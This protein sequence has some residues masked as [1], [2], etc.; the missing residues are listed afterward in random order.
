MIALLFHGKVSRWRLSYLDFAAEFDGYRTSTP[1]IV[2]RPQDR[3]RAA[4]PDRVPAARI[5]VETCADPL[6]LV[7]GG[8]D[9]LWDSG[10]MAKNIAAA[11]RKSQ[12]TQTLIYPNAGH[13]IS[14][15]DWRPNT[16]YNVALS[17]KGGTPEGN[18]HA[19]ADADADAWPKT[20]PFLKRHL[21]PVPR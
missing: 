11:R 14:G 17:K 4:N 3:G 19:H 10:G 6:L 13:R 8:D 1:V 21:G 5:P 15:D 2:R 7:A 16:Q 9:R 20:L 18:A 12:I